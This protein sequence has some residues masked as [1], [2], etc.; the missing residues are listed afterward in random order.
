MDMLAKTMD[1]MLQ[2]NDPFQ[3]L[4]VRCGNSPLFVRKVRE[5]DKLNNYYYNDDDDD[6][7]SG[8]LEV[9]AECRHSRDTLVLGHALLG[10]WANGQVRAERLRCCDLDI[11]S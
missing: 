5:I 4:Q 10:V 1:A 9:A 7:G 11:S 3:V 6:V 8:L 2:S